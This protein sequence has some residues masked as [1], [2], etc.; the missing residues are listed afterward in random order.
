MA[1]NV[2]DICQAR[3]EIR[4]LTHMKTFPDWIRNWP[5]DG[6]E[7]LKDKRVAIVGCAAAAIQVTS[8]IAPIVK[9]VSFVFAVSR[10]ADHSLIPFRH[11]LT[12]F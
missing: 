11:S 12:P 2:G 5:K 9:D 1:H 6:L 10:R 3:G 4:S 8:T 7:V